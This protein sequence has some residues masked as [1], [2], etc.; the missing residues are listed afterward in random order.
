MI[1]ARMILEA[2]T[3]ESAKDATLDAISGTSQASRLVLG[4]PYSGEP[5]HH[6][7]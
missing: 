2:L 5:R 1:G 7:N 4:P 6:F 3:M